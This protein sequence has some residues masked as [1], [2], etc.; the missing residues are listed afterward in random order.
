MIQLLAPLSPLLA[1]ASSVA[2]PAIATTRAQDEGAS[3][4]WYDVRSI[5]TP[6][7]ADRQN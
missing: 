5:P 3:V 6:D 7:L 1:L 4:R 2:G